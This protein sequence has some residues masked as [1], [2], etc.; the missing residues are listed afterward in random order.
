MSRNPDVKN[1]LYTVI[2]KNTYLWVNFTHVT[3]DHT[4]GVMTDVQMFLYLR[5]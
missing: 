3:I 5:I 4:L 2:G 1:E